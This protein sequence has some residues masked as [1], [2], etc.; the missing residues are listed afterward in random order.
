MVDDRST[1]ENEDNK[2]LEEKEQIHEDA[3]GKFYQV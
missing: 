3:E 1:V 2:T